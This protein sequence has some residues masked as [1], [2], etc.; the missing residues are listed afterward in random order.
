MQQQKRI[1]TVSS[2]TIPR[3][4]L[5]ISAINKRVLKYISLTIISVVLFQKTISSFDYNS[6]INRYESIRTPVYLFYVVL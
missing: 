1:I 5:T 2:L 6:I 4:A 3:C